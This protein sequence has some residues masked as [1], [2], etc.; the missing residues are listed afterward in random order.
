MKKNLITCLCI[1]V[2]AIMLML[3][4]SLPVPSQI[5]LVNLKV[6]IVKVERKAARLQV[7]VHEGGNSDVQYIEIDNNTNFSCNNRRITYDRAWASFRPGMIIRVKG[8]Y[9]VAFHVKAKQ[10]YW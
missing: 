10:V 6:K 4:A 3:Q 8:G 2:F 9:T 1:T 7:R 5:I